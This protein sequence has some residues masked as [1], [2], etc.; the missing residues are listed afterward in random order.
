M[1]VSTVEGAAEDV[2]LALPRQQ[3]QVL[4]VHRNVAT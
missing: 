2:A 4:E 1:N 3:L